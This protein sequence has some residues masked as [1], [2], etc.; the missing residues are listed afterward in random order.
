MLMLRRAAVFVG[1]LTLSSTVLVPPAAATTPVGGTTPAAVTEPAGGIRSAAATQAATTA[2]DLP[3]TSVA[4]ASVA[5]APVVRGLPAERPMRLDTQVVDEAD[6]LG[7]RRGE[8]QSALQEL[9]QETGLQLFVV[10]VQTFSGRSAQN[11]ADETAERSDLGTR[12]ALLAVATRDRSYAY[13]FDRDYPLTDAQLDQ[14]ARVAI[15]PPLGANDWAGAAI[16]AAD[17]YQAVL[18]RTTIPEP[19]IQPGPP[20][21]PSSGERAASL[22]KVLVPLGLILAGLLALW[23]VP[24]ARRRKQARESAALAKAKTE[25]IA[26]RANVLLVEL[27]NELRASEQELVLATG[28]YGPEAT[29]SFTAALAAARAELGEAFRLRTSLDQDENI[30]DPTRRQRLL[31]IVERCERADKGLDA[32]AEAFEK[33]RGIE[34]RVTEFLTALATRRADLD[35]RAGRAEATMTSLHRRYTDSALSTVAGDVTEARERLAFAAATLDEAGAAAREQALPRAALGVRTAEEALGQVETLLDGIE[36]LDGDLT[37]AREAADALLAELD[38][39]IAQG[40]A[41]LAGRPLP[42][43]PGQPPMHGQHSMPGQPPVAGQY[44]TPGRPGVPGGGELPPERQAELTAA[45]TRAEQVTAAVRAEFAGPTTDPQAAVHRLEEVDAAMDRALASSI[46]A[47]Q[48]VAR[49]RSLLPRSIQV[50]AAEID[51][52]SR[53]VHTRRG[54]VGQHPRVLLAEAGQHLDRARSLAEVDPVTALAAAQQASTLAGRASQAARSDVNTWN[55][56]GFAGHGGGSGG[57][58]FWGA[59]LGG[60]LSGN[61]SGGTWGGGYGGSSSRSRRSSSSYRS[62]GSSRRSSGSSSRRSGGGR[63]SGGRRGGGGRF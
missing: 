61:S 37:A 12:D 62:S 48:R 16:G 3:A 24:K 25:E 31:E 44:S 60:I 13:S 15:E 17:G 4:G 8:V 55:Q 42:L 22:A 41:L 32:E 23:L 38:T 56:G 45:V 33:L 14:V 7:D 1:V 28:Q 58:A 18:D 43:P 5:V 29:A 39:E 9:R 19:T 49:A 2:Y 63:S 54:A 11:W 34:P 27:D 52:A 21:T 26:G 40:R 35:Q 47:A 51:S 53:F 10:Y 46:E 59:L 20:D 6:V 30:D 57:D 50:A 36:R